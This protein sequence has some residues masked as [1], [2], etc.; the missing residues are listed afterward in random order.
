MVYADHNFILAHPWHSVSHSQSKKKGKV[1]PIF[2][3]DSLYGSAAPAV[4]VPVTALVVTL[5]LIAQTDE[6]SP[7]RRILALGTGCHDQPMRLPSPTK[8]GADS[9]VLAPVVPLLQGINLSSADGYEGSC[10]HPVQDLPQCLPPTLHRYTAAR[11]RFK[12][13]YRR[14]LSPPR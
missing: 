4:V 1:T 13:T 12:R 5:A 9:C 11:C 3:L 10:Q 7:H 2:I 6:V 8:W 14:S